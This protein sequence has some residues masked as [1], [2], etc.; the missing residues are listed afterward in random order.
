VVLSVDAQALR[1]AVVLSVDTL[2]LGMAVVGSL[3]I[4][5]KLGEISASLIWF[6]LKELFSEDDDDFWYPEEENEN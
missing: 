5:Y 6:L 2:F 1:M 3:W 4:A